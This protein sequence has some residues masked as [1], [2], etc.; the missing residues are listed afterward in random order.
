M[1]FLVTRAYFYLMQALTSFFYQPNILVIL[2]S[3]LKTWS[4]DWLL[5]LF[6]EAVLCF[7][8]TR[9]GLVT[10][11]QSSA[12]GLKCMVASI[13]HHVIWKNE[14]RKTSR[15]YESSLPQLLCNFISLWFPWLPLWL[16]HIVVSTL[17]WVPC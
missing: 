14:L 8:L 2:V 12:S 13:N 5:F 1:N 9:S 16:A 15:W 6:K 4:P 11:I 3:I 17:Y 10:Y 7:G